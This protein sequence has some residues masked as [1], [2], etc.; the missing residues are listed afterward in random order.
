MDDIIQRILEEITAK[1][2]EK[3]NLVLFTLGGSFYHD[4]KELEKTSDLDLIIIYDQVTEQNYTELKQDMKEIARQYSAGDFQVYVDAIVGPVK[5]IP[6]QDETALL[7]D[8]MLF[9]EETFTKKYVRNSPLTSYSLSR[10]DAVLGNNIRDLVDFVKPNKEQ[11]LNATSG[12]AWCKERIVDKTA[13]TISWEKDGK[14]QNKFKRNPVNLTDAH[15]K[16]LVLYSVIK[17]ALNT[18][19]VYDRLDQNVPDE[20]IAEKFEQEFPDFV[21]CSYPK[22]A[23]LQKRLLRSGEALDV[24]PEKVVDFLD[25]LYEYIQNK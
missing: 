20:I 5:R 22:E 9:E 18:L 11:L 10:Y 3:E 7:L 24:N 1:L 17:A 25:A 6:K 4:G 19:R 15:H 23:V 8:L 2:A 21:Y 12:I 13:W 16:E 14:F